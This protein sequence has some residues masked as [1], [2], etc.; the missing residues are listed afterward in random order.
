MNPKF[1]VISGRKV[2]AGVATAALLAAEGRSGHQAADRDERGDAAAIRAEG[3][4][5]FIE[6]F[7]GCLKQRAFPPQPDR[8]PHQTPHVGFAWHGAWHRRRVTNGA[9]RRIKH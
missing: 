2:G 3:A 1:Y 4:I 7:N 8:V 5:P 6:G 9:R